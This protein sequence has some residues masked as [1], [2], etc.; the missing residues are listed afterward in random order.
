MQTRCCR[1]GG[2]HARS[3]SG[4]PESFPEERRKVQ[5]IHGHPPAAS[6]GAAISDPHRDVSEPSSSDRSCFRCSQF[7]SRLSFTNTRPPIRTRGR[8]HFE[9]APPTPR[10]HHFRTVD[11]STLTPNCCLISVTTSFGVSNCSFM[12]GS[13]YRVGKRAKRECR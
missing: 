3:L 2:S 5:K 8:Q 13:G 12:G 1:S 11:T 7:C 10:V 6:S 4:E 9:F